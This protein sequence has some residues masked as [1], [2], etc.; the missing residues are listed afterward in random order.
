MPQA[1]SPELAA[2]R[3]RVRSFVD[4][5][6]IPREAELDADDGAADALMHELQSR[7]KRERLWALGHP[8][9][10]GGGG[11]PFLD[12]VHVNEVVGRS[13]HAMAPLG[14]HSL[15]DSLM[16]HLFA[17]EEQKQRYLYPLV[18]AEIYPSVG[19]TEPEVAGSDPTQVRTTAVLDGDQWVIN[20]HKWFTTWAHRA[21]FTTVFARTDDGGEAHRQFSMIIVPTDTPGYEL[22]RV[23]PTMGG[24]GGGHCGI[25]LTDGRGPAANLLGERGAGVPI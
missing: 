2:L 23:I 21:A 12:Y 19:M 14:T 16:L 15:Q 7:A 13:E 20:G 22:V 10:I 25:R 11:L 6:V 17:S 5:Q 18:S 4:E 3:R 1:I 8:T 9:E 24:T